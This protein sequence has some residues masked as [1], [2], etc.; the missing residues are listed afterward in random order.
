MRVER[1]SLTSVRWRERLAAALLGAAAV[2]L[3]ASQQG[4]YFPPAW[5]W[6]AFG[7]LLAAALGLAFRPRVEVSV[8]QWALLAGIGSVLLWTAL[9]TA[10]SDS[11]PRTVDEVERTLI[12]VA[13]IGAVMFVVSR[14]T[15]AHLLGGV[16][17]AV[18][19][20][21]AYALLNRPSGHD[22]LNP[23]SGPLGYWN[24][25]GILDALSLLLALG[26][27]FSPRLPR[28]ARIGALVA[29]AVLAATLYLTYSRGS[30]AALGAGLLMF[31]LCHPWLAERRRRLAAAVLA[32]AAVA[33]LVTAL[34][35]TGGTGR[36]VGKTYAAFRSP[37]APR[38][39]PSQRLLSLSG[40]FR[41]KYW[42]V[43]WKEYRSHPWLGSGA[44]TF[45]LYWDRY[46]KTSY[47]ARD[48]HNL[49]LE[50]LA[51][52][53]PI[54]LLLLVVTLL[55]PFG[56]LRS[57]GRDPVL[58]GA[59]GAYLV[60]LLHAAVDWDWEMPAVTIAGL[61]CGG[62]LT[63]ARPDRRTL[64]SPI[65]WAALATV[66]ALGI[67]VAIAWRGNQA[68]AAST[69]D[70]A[71]GHSQAALAEAHTA[72]RLL[73]WDSEPWTLLGVVELAGGHR[74]NART[75]LRTAVAKDPHDWYP[76][77]ELAR[78]S[79]GKSRQAALRRA[80]RLNPIGIRGVPPL[81]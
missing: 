29:L 42:S 78:A 81:R 49:Y 58:A 60:F 27:V 37:P 47:G 66:A 32:A 59:A 46:R 57:A 54:G 64:A 73:P 43:A 45:D 25:L 2:A 15:V 4:A 75:D 20:V 19:G 77:Y 21:S 70:A 12:Y 56:A 72:A 11:V 3:P 50:T 14:E 41:P 24:A 55:L 61:L 79:T 10:W 36:L 17:A 18:V 63:L 5:G 44:G 23:L 71:H 30:M 8:L 35:L 16:V 51:E 52:I 22:Q 74:R 67:F 34:A 48:A 31:A 53:G 68:K 28:A 33:A 26:F 80:T 65:R 6:T 62:A 38:G 76:W 13:A 7:L 9:S 1:P 39:E 69:D 40:N